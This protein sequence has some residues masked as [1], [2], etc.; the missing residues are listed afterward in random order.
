MYVFVLLMMY[1]VSG[2]QRAKQ[3]RGPARSCGVCGG[4][5]R[6]YVSPPSTS[7]CVTPSLAGLPSAGP[8]QLTGSCTKATPV[9]IIK[10]SKLNPIQPMVLP[11]GR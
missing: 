4:K 7:Y 11:E 3:R 2:R 5:A 9:S 6:V 8:L 10:S 1:L